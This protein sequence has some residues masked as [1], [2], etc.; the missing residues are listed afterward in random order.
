M[1]CLLFH[2]DLLQRI[3]P[4]ATSSRQEN[5]TAVQLKALFALMVE[6]V[7]HVQFDVDSFNLSDKKDTQ[8]KT[9]ITKAI[10]QCPNPETTML[11]LSLPNKIRQ[12]IS[13]NPAALTRYKYQTRRTD[14]QLLLL[15]QASR[16]LRS[17]VDQGQFVIKSHTTITP[18]KLKRNAKIPSGLPWRR[19]W[20]FVVLFLDFLKNL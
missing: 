1:P 4:I 17:Q 10:G 7:M 14:S 12:E 16:H 3:G 6:C 19:S 18:A 2:D 9:W 8:D 13:E 15:V 20:K 5:C 11:F